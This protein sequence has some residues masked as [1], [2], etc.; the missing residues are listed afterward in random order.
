MPDSNEILTFLKNKEV[1]VIFSTMA[2]ALLKK[3]NTILDNIF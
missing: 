3:K 1:L 2:R